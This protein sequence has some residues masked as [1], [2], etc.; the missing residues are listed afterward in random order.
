MG[1]ATK[2]GKTV[3]IKEVL[4]TRGLESMGYGQLAQYAMRDTD[5][6]LTAKAIYAF[7]CSLA[8]SG[9]TTYPSRDT[10]VSRLK[11][12]RNIYYKYRKM[13]VDQGY[14]TVEQHKNDD[15]CF[16]RTDF[17]I[18]DKPPKFVADKRFDSDLTR[19]YGTLTFTGMKAAGYGNICKTVMYDDRLSIKAKGLYAYFVSYAGAGNQVIPAQKTI[20]YHLGINADS[21]HKYLAELTALN[22]LIVTQRH[23]NGRLS[24]NDYCFVSNPDEEKAVQPKPTSKKKVILLDPSTGK[25]R[26]HQEPKIS[27]T[28]E[29]V[30]L[31][32]IRQEPK[33]GDTDESLAPQGIHQ[34]PK[35]EDTGKEDTGKENTEIEDTGKQYPVI[36][37]Q[38]NIPSSSKISLSNNS[39][40]KYQSIYPSTT[41]QAAE[42]HWIDMMDREE[43]KNYILDEIDFAVFSSPIDYPNNKGDKILQL[44]D[45]VTATIA[46]KSA[47]IRIGGEEKPRC[48]TV[49]ILLSLTWGHYDFVVES[50]RKQ[51]NH[52]RN[53]PAYY[54]TSLYNSVASLDLCIDRQVEEDLNMDKLS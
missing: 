22:Y 31:Q 16:Y 44:V 42:T 30:A 54:L 53:I 34:E 2:M 46:R 27:D 50:V 15:G 37:D 26:S 28:D 41:Q 14:L 52:I 29:P 4:R 3:E 5:L 17:I 21:Y 13:L 33:I 7:L 38:S 19:T 9:T 49:D 1:K 24:V 51:A 20:L 32:G 39:S 12:G 6:P 8:G 48:E 40:F 11:I 45:L 47:T 35:N 23:V 25:E 43:I 10:I 36:G 18:E